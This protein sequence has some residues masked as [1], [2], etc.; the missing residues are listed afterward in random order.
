MNSLVATAETRQEAFRADVTSAREA[1]AR[2]TAQAIKTTTGVR[3]TG[4][5]R[6]ARQAENE[7]EDALEIAPGV[8]RRQ[9]G[10]GEPHR[11]KSVA[12]E[13]QRQATDRLRRKLVLVGVTSE[14]VEYLTPE[15]RERHA[16]LRVFDS[17]AWAH[18]RLLPKLE[19]RRKVASAVLHPSCSINHLKL[20]KKLHVLAAAMADEAVTPAS[21]ECCGFAGDRGFLHTEL[22]RSATA[23]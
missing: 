20:T 15:N 4:A 9:R 2:Q 19:I 23:E 5:T 16:Q 7:A 6:K 1:D 10:N 18:D 3:G 17:V 12:L 13:R 8:R 21:H 22:T 14:I 11:G